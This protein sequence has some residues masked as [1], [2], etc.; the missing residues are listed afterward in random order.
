MSDRRLVV[1]GTRLE[2]WCAQLRLS[3]LDSTAVAI[4]VVFWTTV[5]SSKA[6]DIAWRGVRATR[7]HVSVPCQARASV[8]IVS[9]SAC[10]WGIFLVVYGR[11][12]WRRTAQKGL[13]VVAE[14]NLVA[15][16][17]DV[18]TVQ[19]TSVR[20]QVGSKK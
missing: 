14:D 12:E 8:V 5:S 4:L 3:I 18:I 7:V 15:R 19:Q 16:Y 20:N 11:R 1:S 9:S 17:M 10:V 2:N 13:H 6:W